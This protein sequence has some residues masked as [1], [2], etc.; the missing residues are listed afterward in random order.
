MRVY[1]SCIEP[2]GLEL[3]KSTST[4][5]CDCCGKPAN[6]RHWETLDFG[7]INSHWHQWGN[8]CGVSDQS[9]FAYDSY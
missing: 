4:T 3:V 6:Y 8:H 9:P 5:E 1:G 7:C 2:G